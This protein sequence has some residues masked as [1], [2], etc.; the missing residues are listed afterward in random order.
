MA[1]KEDTSKF[2]NNKFDLLEA[3]QILLN[4]ATDD[5]FDIFSENLQNL[6]NY[7]LPEEAAL[8]LENYTSE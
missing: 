8:C 3:K 4:N 2:E 1:P 7:F 5:N 6:N